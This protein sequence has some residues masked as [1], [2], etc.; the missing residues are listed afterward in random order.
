MLQALRYCFYFNFY[1][2]ETGGAPYR[3]AF[4]SM[5]NRA[6]EHVSGAFF[7]PFG[8]EGAVAY[9]CGKA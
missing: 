8:T 9:C 6:S 7:M 4:K 1:A 5:S 2:F 3:F